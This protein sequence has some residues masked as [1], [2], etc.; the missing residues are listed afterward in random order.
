M[1][2]SF[3]EQP[4]NLK[5]KDLNVHGQYWKKGKA[6]ILPLYEAKMFQIFDHRVGSVVHR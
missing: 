2:Q 4:K 6:N 1:M 5:Q 3:F